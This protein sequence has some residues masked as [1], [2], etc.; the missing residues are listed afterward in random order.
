M[1]DITIKNFAEQ[2]RVAPERLLEQLGSAGVKAGSVDDVLSDEDKVKLLAFLKGGASQPAERKRVTLK[3]K[4][5]SEIK[6]TSKT[7]AAH[8]VHVEVRK[9]RT[10]VKRTDLVEEAEWEAR[11]ERGKHEARR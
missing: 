9:R 10:F 5:T 2:I 3:R 11:R 1:A 7:G 8:T 4:T 6:Q